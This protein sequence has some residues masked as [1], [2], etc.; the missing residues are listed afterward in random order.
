MTLDQWLERKRQQLSDDAVAKKDSQAALHELLTLFEQLPSEERLE[1]DHVVAT[2]LES[3]D[4]R[5]RFDAEF[6]IEELTIRS[7]VPAL[8]RLAQS[9]TV[10][11]DPFAS[12]ELAKVTRILHVLSIR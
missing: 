5:K 12:N 11:A 1:A 4:E 3:S 2:W 9:L 10:S 8:R 7:A 6:I